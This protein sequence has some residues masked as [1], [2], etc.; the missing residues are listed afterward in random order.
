MESCKLNTPET[1]GQIVI[2]H[3]P[4]PKCLPVKPGRYR[5]VIG[6][7]SKTEYSITSSIRTAYTAKE[8]CEA[9]LAES[10]SKS[11]RRP[12]TQQ[13]LYDLLMSI[14]LSERKYKL[15]EGLIADAEEECEK[16]QRANRSAK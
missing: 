2:V 14:R 6:A 11:N 4:S 9:R 10:T 12:Q 16:I 15:V 7:A 13:E 1:L 5:V 3:A 8:A